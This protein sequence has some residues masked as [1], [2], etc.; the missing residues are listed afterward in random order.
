MTKKVWIMALA[1]VCAGCATPRPDVSQPQP[2]QAVDMTRTPDVSAARIAQMLEAQPQSET[3]S[4]RETVLATLHNHRG[5]KIVQDNLDVVRHELRRAKAGWGPSLDATGR[6]GANQ[7][8]DSTTRSY[9]TDTGL[10]GASGV[11]LTLTQPLWDGFATRSRVRSGEATVDSMTYRVLDNATS[12]ALDAI[13]AHVDL[14]RRREILRLAEENVEQHLAIL[15]SQEDRLAMGASSS[16]DLTQTQG[17]LARARSTLTDAQASLREAEAN[18][19]RL[20]GKP[21]PAALE[22]VPLPAGMFGDMDGVLLKAREDNPKMKAY[23]AD[24]KAARGDKELAQSTYHPR[25]NL[26][27]GPNY[28]DR[29]GRGNQ[30]ESS[31]DI[32]ATMRWNIFNSG[33]DKAEVEAAESRIR[34]SRETAYNFMDDLSQQISDTW[35]RYRA[36]IETRKYYAEAIVYNTQTRDAYLDQFNLGQRSLLDVLDAENELFNSSTQHATASGNVIVG[37]YRLYALAGDLLPELQVD[38]KTLYEAP[39]GSEGGR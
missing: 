19:I 6:F 34:Q 24:I 31:F 10:Y 11:G 3:V 21:I 5:L 29:S 14:L 37:A 25:I 36:S 9:G 18:Y 33:A 26:E 15:A 35:T 7:V 17:R 27:V 2:G 23:L 8:S 38:G 13:I 20:T 39:S 32:M 12:F 16:A 1:L 4:L 28:S 30:Y 22:E